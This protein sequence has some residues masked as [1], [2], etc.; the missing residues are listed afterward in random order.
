MTFS[1]Q[2]TRTFF[3]VQYMVSI[4]GS[5]VRMVGGL[6]LEKVVSGA[7]KK[8]VRRKFELPSL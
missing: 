2:Q 3:S 4:E 8:G 7:G 5:G 6:F 1:G